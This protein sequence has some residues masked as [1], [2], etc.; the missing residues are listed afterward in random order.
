MVDLSVKNVKDLI[1]AAMGR[2]ENDLVFINCKILNVFTKEFLPGNVYVYQKWISHVEYNLEAPLMAC[3]HV[4]DCHGQILA[5]AFVDAHTHIE[6]SL[7]T[8]QNYAK[9]VAPLGTLTVLQDCHEIANVAGMDGVRYMIESGKNTCM[10]QIATIPSCVPSLPGFENSGA[11]FTAN[12]YKE[13]LDEENVI[14]LG[15]IMDY[16]GIINNENRIH[17]IVS[18]AKKKNVYLQGHAPLVTGNRLSAYMCAGIISDHEAKYK[19]EI[20]QKVRNGMWI[21]IRD[22]NTGK[23]MKNIIP[24]L[25]EIGSFDRVCFSSDDRRCN[26]T[27][28]D[29]HMDGIVRNAV[30]CGMPVINAL[31]S[32]SFNVCQEAGIKHLGAIAPGY[33][34]DI[35]LLNNETDLIVTDVYFE[36][37]N[38][39]TS[40]N[41]PDD[42]KSVEMRSY[43]DVKSYTLDDFIMQCN[44]KSE[45][46]V[47]YLSFE[48]FTSTLTY[49][50]KEQFI[51]KNHRVSL[52]KKENMMF[53]AVFN[54]YGKNLKQ[55][56]IVE[57][58]GI[59]HGALASTISHDSHNITVIFDTPENGYVALKELIFQKGGFCAVENEKVI[60]KMELPIGGLM[61][62]K[63]AEMV[64]KELEEMVLANRKLGNHYLENPVSRITMLSLLVGPYIRI[65]D[66]GLVITE[67]KCII[68]IFDKVNNL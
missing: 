47:N 59:N 39:A 34:A 29:G 40:L 43:I 19:D 12:D 7:L 26:V 63:P 9:M 57:N 1:D 22:A 8:P 54:R 33:M 46:M 25:K 60:A 27:L 50:K 11:V 65:S 58:F 31:I 48:S 30:A 41:Q 53:A 42:F 20:I 23:H 45:V 32:A 2:I 36:G 55:L 21:D 16:Q 24:I 35:I 67:N 18:F 10:R 44:N 17:D 15:E 56:T 4:I 14:G 6:S 61:S 5:P 13:I 51:V 49:H 38:I 28:K 37:T 3:R 66:M 68:D 62:N 52:D 64:A